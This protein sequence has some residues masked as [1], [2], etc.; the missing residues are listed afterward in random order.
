MKS[1]G[2]VGLSPQQV[3]NARGELVSDALRHAGLLDKI[4][5]P[6]QELRDLARQ[7]HTDTLK[8]RDHV[9][10]AERGV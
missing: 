6:T 4:L 8:D 2:N 1:A 10:Q 9:L 3:C 7:S 5:R